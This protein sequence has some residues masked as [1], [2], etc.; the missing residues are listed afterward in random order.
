MRLTIDET[1]RRREKQL[2]YNAE[3]NITPQPLNKSVQT[4]SVFTRKESLAYSEPERIS[5]AADPVVQYMNANQLSK[6]IEKTRK[7]MLG[8]AKD[9]DF[10]TA[11][12]LRDEMQRLQERLNRISQDK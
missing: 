11:A 5:I 2:R 7:A 6:T 12:Q 1:N 10:I 4:P 3:H 8:A 9:L